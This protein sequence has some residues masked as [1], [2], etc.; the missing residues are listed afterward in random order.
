MRWGPL[1]WVRLGNGILRRAGTGGGLF[2]RTTT[3]A[4]QLSSE[5]LTP[6]AYFA[7]SPETR[8]ATS[9]RDVK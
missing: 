9:V 1:Q 5:F 7:S 6:K 2:F 4:L 3:T 8:R